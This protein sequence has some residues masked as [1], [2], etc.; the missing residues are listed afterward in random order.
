MESVVPRVGELIPDRPGNTVPDIAPQTKLKCPEC[1]GDLVQV[2]SNEIRGAAVKTC[3]VCFGRWIEGAELRGM[4][5]RGLFARI[6]DFFKSKN[7]PVNIDA[8]EHAPV[9]GSGVPA[10][11]SARIEPP[12]ESHSQEDRNGS[13]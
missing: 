11:E 7:R 1:G 13:Q 4:K 10:E 3:L 12:E 8:S 6:F 9:T 2:K 5:G